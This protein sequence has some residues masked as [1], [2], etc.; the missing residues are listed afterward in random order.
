MYDWCS[1]SGPFFF[2]VGEGFVWLSARGSVNCCQSRPIPPS[3]AGGAAAAGRHEDTT[4]NNV[5]PSRTSETWT[6]EMQQEF[7]TRKDRWLSRTA[8]LD[9]DDGVVTFMFEHNMF[10]G[11]FI[12]RMLLTLFKSNNNHPSPPRNNHVTIDGI[13]RRLCPRSS[14]FCLASLVLCIYEPSDSATRKKT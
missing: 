12:D 2:E 6:V 4:G 9:A 14:L 13:L 8:A 11:A 1:V 5:I 7:L 3:F 10:L